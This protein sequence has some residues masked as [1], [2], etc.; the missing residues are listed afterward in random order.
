MWQKSQYPS[1]AAAAVIEPDICYAANGGRTDA[2]L[3]SA[4]RLVDGLMPVT[5]PRRAAEYKSY[6]ADT[7]AGVHG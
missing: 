6:Q 2:Q 1:F 3:Q 4:P 5:M 7:L